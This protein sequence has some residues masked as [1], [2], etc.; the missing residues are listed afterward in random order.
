M[1]F[2]REDGRLE[3]IVGVATSVARLNAEGVRAPRG[4]AFRRASQTGL[5]NLKEMGVRRRWTKHE[6]ESVGAEA[7]E[8]A[9]GESIELGPAHVHG[10]RA[11]AGASA[12][13]REG[14]RA[15][16]RSAESLHEQACLRACQQVDRRS[17]ESLHEQACLPDLLQPPVLPSSL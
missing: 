17:A 13:E 2:H 15:D 3:E 5:E 8:L 11:C 10:D 6:Q 7:G 4:A 1:G 9:D 12:A 14:T 16:G